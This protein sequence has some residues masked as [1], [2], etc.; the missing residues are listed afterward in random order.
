MKGCILNRVLALL[1]AVALL[2][3]TGVLVTPVAG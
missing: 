2:T 3:V 1:A